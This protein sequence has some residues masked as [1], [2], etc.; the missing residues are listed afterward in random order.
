MFYPSPLAVGAQ[1]VRLTVKP[2]SCALRW[3][4]AFRA[5]GWRSFCRQSNPK[6]G[7][8][9]TWL[10]KRG[11]SAVMITQFDEMPTT[12]VVTLPANEAAE[13]CGLF[14]KSGLATPA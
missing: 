13:L 11:A 12:Q 1:Q 7:S 4:A 8:K 3:G 6:D 9:L 2:S 14:V 10:L 5:A